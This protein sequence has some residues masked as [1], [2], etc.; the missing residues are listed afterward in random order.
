MIYIYIAKEIKAKVLVSELSRKI[1][2]LEEY[3]KISIIYK[4]EAVCL[5]FFLE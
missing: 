2:E 1:A 5:F 3:K 4:L